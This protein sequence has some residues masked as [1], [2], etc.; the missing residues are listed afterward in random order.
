MEL[1]KSEQMN[2]LFN[3]YSKL[4]TDK[5][6]EYMSLYYAEDLSLGEIAEQFNVSR[7]AVYDNLK[8]SEDILKHY[9]NNLGMVNNTIL[10]NELTNELQDYVN[11][12]YPNDKK[13]VKMV[14]KLDALSNR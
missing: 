3:F 4:L 7:Q 8:R 10:E 6:R 9:E 14:K 12:N 11:D 5:Q 13:L 2:I 1:E